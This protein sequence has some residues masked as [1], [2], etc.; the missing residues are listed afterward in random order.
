MEP[1]QREKVIMKEHLSSIEDKINTLLEARDY[2]TKKIE[3]YNEMEE[4]INGE[5]K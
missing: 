2:V 5:G 4:K 3:I 1:L